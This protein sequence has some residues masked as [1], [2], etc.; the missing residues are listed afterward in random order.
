MQ[1]YGATSKPSGNQA[2]SES[3]E[4]APNHTA[5]SCTKVDP[6]DPDLTAIVGAWPTLPDA[7]KAGV[8]ALV[9]AAECTKARESAENKR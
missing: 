6:I 9:R 2:K 3:P 4:S 5:I 1:S 8:L 7:I